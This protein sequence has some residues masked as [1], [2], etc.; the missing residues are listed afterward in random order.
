MPNLGGL[1]TLESISPDKSN[2]SGVIALDHTQIAALSNAVQVGL[3]HCLSTG[4]GFVKDVVYCPVYDASYN[5]TGWVAVM[6][7]HDHSANDDVTGGTL[8]DIYYANGDKAVLIPYYKLNPLDFRLFGTFSGGG[9][10]WD[11]SVADVSKLFLY[12]GTTD[13]NNITLQ[14][15]GIRLLF[16]EKMRWDMKLSASHQNEI[17]TRVGVNIDRLNQTQSTTRRQMGIE[18]CFGTGVAGHGIYWAVITSK[19]TSGNLTATNS[20]VPI[21]AVADIF[22]MKLI[23]AVEARFFYAGTSYA[24]STSSSTPFDG[25][26]DH[27]KQFRMGVQ[28]LDTSQKAIWFYGGH[29]IAAP[30]LSF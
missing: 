5:R 29:Q 4:G 25:N 3:V 14:A 24:A 9:Y 7:K 8:M 15:D 26:T 30:H 22:T 6:R 18:G 21:N 1:K 10:A 20:L 27:D 13:D 12:T 17:Y 19:G 11:D 2:A 16:S 23:P 28:Q